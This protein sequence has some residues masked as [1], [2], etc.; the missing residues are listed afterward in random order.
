MKTQPR[1]CFLWGGNATEHHHRDMIWQSK[2][3]EKGK[4]RISHWF[5]SERNYTVLT[6]FNLCNLQFSVSGVV[7]SFGTAFTDIQKYVWITSKIFIGVCVNDYDPTLKL[8][9]K[10]IKQVEIWS[11]TQALALLPTSVTHFLRA[12]LHH[13]LWSYEK[14]CQVPIHEDPWLMTVMAKQGKTKTS[15]PMLAASNRAEI[16]ENKCKRKGESFYHVKD[17]H[18]HTQCE[19]HTNVH[20]CTHTHM[21][22]SNKPKSACKV[23]TWETTAYTHRCSPVCLDHIWT[24]IQDSLRLI[25]K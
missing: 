12:A 24:K 1:A 22:R 5:K 14:S 21:L 6:A 3:W 4:K 20:V 10:V 8:L 9:G 25:D 7:H 13:K 23:H 18:T 16:T 19:T 2:I 11:A 15:V 17:T